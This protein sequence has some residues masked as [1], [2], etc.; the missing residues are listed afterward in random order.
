MFKTIDC[1]TVLVVF[2]ECPPELYPSWHKISLNYNCPLQNVY[3][4]FMPAQLDKYH[5]L[6]N[7]ETE[8]FRI[9]VKRPGIA[10]KG[11]FVKTLCEHDFSF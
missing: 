6:R 4:L 3:C 8:I 2:P 5:S 11:L 9:T 10:F 7:H 1:I